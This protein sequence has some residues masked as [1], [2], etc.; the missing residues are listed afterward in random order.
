MNRPQVIFLDAV[1]TLFGVRGSVGEVY[2]DITRQFGVAADAERLNQAFFQSFKAASPMAFPSAIASD[3]PA[4]EYAW[5]EAIAIETFRR[6]DLLAQFTDFSAFFA[7]LY[8]HFATAAPWFVY[9]DTHHTLSHW[10]NQGIELGVL[11][12]FDSRLYPV[13]SAL[14]LAE[15]FSSVTISTEVGAAKPDRRM[16]ET[17][18]AKHN[19]PANAAW[20]IGDSF[21]EDYQGATAAGL[22]AFWLKR[23]D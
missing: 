11:S 21:K 19:C 1:G 15:Y 2:T 10:R 18:L 3:I 14:G 13:L 7:V 22:Q 5:W 17:A 23:Q 4:K 12:N 16:F 20:H 6:A 9:P 8:D